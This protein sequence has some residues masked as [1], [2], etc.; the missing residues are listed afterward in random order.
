MR[1]CDCRVNC[2]VRVRVRVGVSMSE[3]QPPVRRD[4]VAMPLSLM[5]VRIDV[6]N[7]LCAAPVLE[8]GYRVMALCCDESDE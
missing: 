6:C 7:A 4:N 3:N 1:V 2:R 5:Y 8:A